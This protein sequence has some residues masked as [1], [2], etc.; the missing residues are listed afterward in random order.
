MKTIASWAQLLK[1]A[2][3]LVLLEDMAVTSLT[4]NP[5]AEILCKSWCL[6]AVRTNHEYQDALE[7]A[8][9]ELVQSEQ[10]T[11]YVRARRWPASLIRSAW[12]LAGAGRTATGIFIGGWAQEYLY[13]QRLLSYR[14]MRSELQS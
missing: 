5:L 3:Q 7:Q 13:S 2:G 12:W 14:F 9:L 8:G 6:P 4:G 11:E 10:F 1:P